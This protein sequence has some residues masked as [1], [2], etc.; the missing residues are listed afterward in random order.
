MMCNKRL[1]KVLL[2]ENSHKQQF[3]TVILSNKQTSSF[4]S[5]HTMHSGDKW[6]QRTE[7]FICVEGMVVDNKPFNFMSCHVS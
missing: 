7:T 2:I 5:M 6:L 1:E 4:F 3:L